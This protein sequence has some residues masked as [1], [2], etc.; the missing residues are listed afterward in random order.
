MI[1][2]AVVPVKH[3]SA[4]KSRL[5]AALA[6]RER[7]ALV[8]SM[9]VHTLKTLGAVKRITGVIVVSRDRAVRAVVED[10]GAVFVCEALHDGMNRALVRGVREAIRRGAEAV[11][12]LPA[13]LPL[14][15]SADIG[16]ALQCT[17]HPPFV[18]IAPD[19]LG[20]GTNMLFLAPPGL[21]RPTFGVG[22][23]RRHLAA[24]R[25]AGTKVVVLRRKSFARDVDCPEDLEKA[26]GLEST[27]STKRLQRSRRIEI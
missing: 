8:R 23:F 24:A 2:W 18:L 20:E 9:L 10:Q 14:L 11:M 7:R 19:H 17:G 4:A 22:S 5:A 27:Q 6:L 3:L 21:I 26:L 16:W 13:D 12:I 25:Q 1:C 15:K